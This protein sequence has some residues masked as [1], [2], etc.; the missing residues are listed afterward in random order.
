VLCSIHPAFHFS[1][2]HL[3]QAYINHEMGHPDEGGWAKARLNWARR[4]ATNRTVRPTL[5]PRPVDDF[6]IKR[7]PHSGTG[8]AR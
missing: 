6:G 1:P 7:R 2:P 8:R 5:P 4:A 3:P